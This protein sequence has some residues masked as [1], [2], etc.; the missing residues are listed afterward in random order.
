ME[1][2]VTAFA[3]NTTTTLNSVTFLYYFFG[4]FFFLLFIA[5]IIYLYN[6]FALFTIAKKTKIEFEWFAFIPY[7]N[8]YLMH[9]I[10]K[11]PPW[12]LIT[13]ITYLFLS[14]ALLEIPKA[15]LLIL[16]TFPLPI[17]ISAVWIGNMAK[18]LNYSFWLGF[19]IPILQLISLIAFIAGI[20]VT[21]LPT[22]DPTITKEYASN[23]MVYC[24]S[25]ALFF[26]LTSMALFG[27]IAWRNPKVK[28]IAKNKK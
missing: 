14:H 24:M 16:L 25:S 7:L 5:L 18:R 21:T 15:G 2:I 10:A 20:I 22:N 6:A 4:I 28:K 9:L 11:T 23:I 1:N 27:I 12:M 13:V 26:Y 19:S 17:I 8:I 3:T